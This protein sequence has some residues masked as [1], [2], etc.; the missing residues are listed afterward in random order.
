VK[1]AHTPDDGFAQRGIDIAVESDL[2]DDVVGGDAE[3]V[4]YGPYAVGRPSRGTH[5]VF[6]PHSAAGSSARLKVIFVARGV[7]SAP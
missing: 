7:D 6:P 5:V 3:F 1:L 4:D 2:H